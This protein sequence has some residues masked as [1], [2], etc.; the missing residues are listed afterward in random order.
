MMNFIDN[1]PIIWITYVCFK[2]VVLVFSHVVFSPYV[3][4]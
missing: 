4:S 3:P 2:S 1:D